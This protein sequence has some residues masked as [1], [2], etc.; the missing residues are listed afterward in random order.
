MSTYLYTNEDSP[1]GQ[2]QDEADDDDAAGHGVHAVERHV[3]EAPVA[4]RRHLGYAAHVR[5]QD[6]RL[7]AEMYIGYSM[8]LCC[9]IFLF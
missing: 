1:D 2:E 6:G 3:R 7:P 9:F 8:L 5:R 4:Q